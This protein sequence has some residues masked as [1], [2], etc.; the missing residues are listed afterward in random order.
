MKT[1]MR[2]TLSRTICAGLAA[3]LLCASCGKVEPSYEPV[4]VSAQPVSTEVPAANAGGE[5]GKTVVPAADKPIEKPSDMTLTGLADFS[6]GLLKN[7]C[8]AEIKEGKNVLISPESVLMALGMTA[9]G[10]NGETLAQM[11]KVML[12]EEDISKLND[13]MR[14]LGQHNPEADG[15]KVNI[16]NSIWANKE[17]GF[18]LKQSFADTVKQL[19]GAESFCVPFNDG[20]TL[21]DIN[22]W[23]SNNTNGMIPTILD[24][25]PPNTELYLINAMA[26]EAEWYNE[27]EETDMREGMNFTN[28]AGEEEQCSFLYSEEAQYFA[29]GSAQAF[30]KLYKGGNY[31][32]MGILPN[33]GV[34]V[35]DYI[36]GLDGEG[37]YKLW[38]S[39]EYETVDVLMPEFTY[40]YNS[41]LNDGLKAMGMELPFTEAADFTGIADYAHDYFYINRVIHKTHIEVDR[42]GTKAAAA[43]AIEMKCEDACL[44]VEEPKY[45]HL[46]RPFVYAIVDME[47]GF[48]VFLGAVNTVK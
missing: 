31:A 1:K 46:D 35:S 20:Q 17:E 21:D 36:A 13:A 25:I 41:I 2:K 39:R 18:S 45:I 40:D 37:W 43:T 7:N 42:K 24:E 16:A 44:A 30:V 11:E 5:S 6:A 3:M 22:G 38:N 26:F 34:S 29:D 14:Y 27:Y 28:F 19:Y 12:G 32:F 4:Q 23:V 9:N 47:T 48:P 10:A 33:E 8:G 15:V